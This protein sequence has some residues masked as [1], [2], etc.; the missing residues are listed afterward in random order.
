MAGT[1]LS[2]MRSFSEVHAGACHEQNMMT[3]RRGETQ[4]E[5]GDCGEF[6]GW[7]PSLLLHELYLA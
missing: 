2:M 4:D 7:I 3:A 1:R 6:M 5:V